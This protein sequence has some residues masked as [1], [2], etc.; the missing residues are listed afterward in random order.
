MSSRK[1]KYYHKAKKS[2]LRSRASFKILEIQSKFELL[3]EGDLVLE[4]GASPGGWTQV[5][6]EI[7]GEPVVALDIEKMEP[8]EG[9]IFLKGNVFDPGL[10]TSLDDILSQLG[11]EGFDVIVS[12]AMVK[13]SG[14]RNIDNSSS[15]L[16]CKRVMEIAGSF[17]AEGGNVLVK[18]F[19]G[20]LTEQ[21]FNEWG[22]NYRFRKKTSPR[23]S[24]TGSRELY[25]IFAGKKK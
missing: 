6:S 11:R 3:S 20:D 7:T 13:T 9:V 24:R 22:R 8:M 17:L 1:D 21:F 2:G 12:D 14:D 10:E 19:Q 4:I 23:A 15:Y 16:L 25:I 18:Q 5:I